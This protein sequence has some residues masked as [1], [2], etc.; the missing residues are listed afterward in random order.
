[1][2][3]PKGHPIFRLI[4]SKVDVNL[5]THLDTVMIFSPNQTDL[6]SMVFDFGM[7][8]FPPSS[9]KGICFSVPV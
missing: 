3:D 2:L 9:I 8:Y 5:T 6:F 4:I 7:T 1:M